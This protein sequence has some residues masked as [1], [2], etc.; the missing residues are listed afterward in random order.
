MVHLEDY[1]QRIFVHFVEYI[2]KEKIQIEAKSNVIIEI[3]TKNTLYLN[4]FSHILQI[5]YILHKY[6]M[7]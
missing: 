1:F 7:T 3:G 2:V 6:P 5:S 4:T